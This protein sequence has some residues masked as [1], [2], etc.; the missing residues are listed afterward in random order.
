MQRR[1]SLAPVDRVLRTSPEGVANIIKR[2]GL[3]KP[4]PDYVSR[5]TPLRGSA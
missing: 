3:I 5:V 1:S 4:Q 2:G